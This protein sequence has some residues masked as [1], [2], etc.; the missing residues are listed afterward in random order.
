MGEVASRWAL[1]ASIALHGAVVAL[2]FARPPSAVAAGPVRAD[3]WGGST[4]E[5]PVADP[6]QGSAAEPPSES[7]ERNRHRGAGSFE[8]RASADRDRDCDP[9]LDRDRDRDL[10][11][12]R[13]PDLDLDPHAPHTGGSTAAGA[14]SSEGGS[15]GGTGTFGAEGSA[16]GVRDLV[17]SFV[18]AI[19][20]VASS[21]PIWAT[22]PL[23]A[24]GAVDVT[25]V[26]DEEL[27]AA[28]ESALRVGDP[29]ASS[30][31]GRTRLCW[32]WRAVGFAV[33][34]GGAAGA[35]QRLHIALA[36]T[37]DAP[38]AQ[39][40]ALRAVRSGFA[41]SPPTITR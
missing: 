27:Q 24:A 11:L 31:A 13:D 39:I 40:S 12:D 30:E 33:G 3:F 10:D 21:D 5:V 9:D 34:A 38:P 25:L 36:I 37:Q 28:H 1:L 16:P 32:S 23:G 26:L 6:G 7:E 19:P 29:S 20:I 2:A 17:R 18:R 14:A 8:W 22:L 41:S 4:F 35:E 15:A